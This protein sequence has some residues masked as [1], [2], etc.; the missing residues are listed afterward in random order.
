MFVWV[1]RLVLLFAV[2]AAVYVAL[3]RYSRWNRR[4][5]LEAEYDVA[6]PAEKTRDDHIAEG[7]ERYDH[8]LSK[9]LLLGVF[10]YPVAVIVL[11]LLIANYM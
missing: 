6:K 5:T 8:S 9:R 1:T 2:L 11:L 4:K 3:S 7:M 10:V